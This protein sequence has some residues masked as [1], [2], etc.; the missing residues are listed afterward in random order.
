VTGPNSK[1][2]GSSPHSSLTPNSFVFHFLISIEW[3]KKLYQP[4]ISHQ[5]PWLSTV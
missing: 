3:L 2:D 1:P 5:T 4:F